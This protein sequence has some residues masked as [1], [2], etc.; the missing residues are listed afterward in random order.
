MSGQKKLTWVKKVSPLL[1]DIALGVLCLYGG[2][3]S[4]R[5][6]NMLLPFD[7]VYVVMPL[8][9]TYY[10]LDL[11]CVRHVPFTRKRALVYPVSIC[12]FA[13]LYL[14][15]AVLAADILRL[16]IRIFVSSEAA[17]SRVFY[18][19]GWLCLAA[20]LCSVTAGIIHAE[21]IVTVKYESSCGKL[22]ENR[23]IVLLTDL[24]IGYFV[25]KKH[26]HSIVERVNSLNPDMVLIS[27]DIFNGGGTEEC[28]ELSDVAEELRRMEPA[29]RIFAVT[30]NHDP[31]PADRSFLEFLDKSGI[32]L[33]KDELCTCG[34]IQLIG[35]PTKTRPRKP[36]KELMSTA[37]RTKPVIVIDHDPIGIA[38]ARRE[39]ADY[40]MCGHTHKGQVFPLNLFVRFIYKKDEAWGMS[41]NGGTTS[42][43]SSG[44]G[45]FSMPMRIGSDSEAV[46]V[47]LKTAAEE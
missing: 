45:F 1:Y 5:W 9:L 7:S 11:L 16:I 42:V 38:E 35:R 23:R 6:L 20:V 3:R 46:C 15:M 31:A 43:V 39:G 21:K 17:L 41:C 37:D 34:D 29:G 40:I 14:G 44:A 30:G 47:D 10:V 13:V 12:T 4:R 22:K 24:H 18:V 26:I 33:L 28:G 19:C 2:I 25:G 8:F 32:R 36:L 27:G